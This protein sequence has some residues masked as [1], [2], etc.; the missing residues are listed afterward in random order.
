MRLRMSERSPRLA[1][2]QAGAAAWA[3]SR[4]A[5]MSSSV[6]RA[7]SQNGLPLTAEMFSKQSRY[8]GSTQ[9]QPMKWP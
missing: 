4:A 5:S 7:I 2:P 8:V 1:P 6:P 9:L 3:A